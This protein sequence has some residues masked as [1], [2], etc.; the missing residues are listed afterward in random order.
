M[1]PKAF[2]YT[3]TKIIEVRFI[4]H[5]TMIFPP[6]LNKGATIGLLSPAGKIDA[7]LLAPLLNIIEQQGYSTIVAPHALMSHFQFAAT[8]KQRLNDLQWMMDHDGID[9][10]LCLRGGYGTVRIVDRLDFT[11]FSLRPKW[12]IGFS[13]ITALHAAVQNKAG[14]VS[15][16]GPMAK[17]IVDAED[18]RQDI[19]WLWKLL[20]NEPLHYNIAPHCLNQVGN[21]SGRLVGGNLSLIYALRGTP[22]DMDTD[23]AILFIEDLNEYLYHLDRMMHNLKLGGLLQRLSGVV[24][25]QFT[26]MKDNQTPFGATAYEIIADAL[27]GSRIPVMFGFPAGHCE[28]NFPLPLGATVTLAVDATNAQ[29]TI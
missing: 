12:L 27:Q 13:D 2:F 29:L 19:A 11:R 23:G 3:F 7:E 15:I 20:R 16:H 10:I 9:A 5:F 8:D 1:A 21:A 24:V 4:D 22:Y 25:G 18:S 14:V 28:P 6:P 26:D 17:H